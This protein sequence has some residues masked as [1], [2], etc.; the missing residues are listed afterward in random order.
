MNLIEITYTK[1]SI[2]YEITENKTT[3]FFIGEKKAKSLWQK[4]GKIHAKSVE[5]SVLHLCFVSRVWRFN[6]RTRNEHLGHVFIILKDILKQL[7]I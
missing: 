5:R 1:L 2:L 3:L 7:M 4:Y 6:K